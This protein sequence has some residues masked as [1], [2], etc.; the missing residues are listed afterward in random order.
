M[1]SQRRYFAWKML[2]YFIALWPWVVSYPPWDPS[3]QYYPYEGIVGYEPLQDLILTV[4]F[5]IGVAMLRRTY[6]RL[7]IA[8]ETLKNLPETWEK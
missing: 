5:V 6:F 1:M 3:P 2:V 8:I 4:A 7:Q